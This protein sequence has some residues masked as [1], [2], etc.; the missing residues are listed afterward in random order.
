[1]RFFDSRPL[2]RRMSWKLGSMMNSFARMSK[3]YQL[4]WGNFFKPLDVVVGGERDF[5]AAKWHDCRL[6]FAAWVFW[7]ARWQRSCRGRV[8]SGEG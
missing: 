8:T 5:Q 7:N 4:G 2:A 6:T 3:K 1:M